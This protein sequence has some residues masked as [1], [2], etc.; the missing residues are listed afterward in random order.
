MRIAIIGAAGKAGTAIAAESLKRGHQ[1]SAIVRHPEN[2][3]QTISFIQKDLFNLERQDLAA[4]DVVVNA[5]SMPPG[6]EENHVTAGRHLI[7]LL[8]GKSTPRLFVV[9]G[10]GS[11]FTDSTKTMRVMD[12]PG[13]PDFVYPTALNQA[14]NL[15]DLQKTTDMS[16]TFL[17]PS[18]TF[19]NGKRT[20]HYQTGADILLI[21]SQGKSYVSYEDFAVAA[22]DELEA[23]KHM[24]QRFTVVSELN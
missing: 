17:S 11:L 10:A 2:L 1:V 19:A 7:H 5:V 20:G 8:S 16:W 22:V 23:P 18:A 12:S 4:F 15:A 14:I 21:N 24:N 3:T 6:Q 13:F 9:G